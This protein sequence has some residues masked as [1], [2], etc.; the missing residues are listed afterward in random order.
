MKYPFLSDPIGI[1][2]RG[3]VRELQERLAE[4]REARCMPSLM[5]SSSSSLANVSAGVERF[6]GRA[7]EPFELLNAQN[8]VK[9]LSEFSKFLRKFQEILKSEEFLILSRKSCE[10]PR[11]FD[12]NR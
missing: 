7:I 9:F 5:P 3:E 4:E 10:I 6:D 12:Q 11:K 2:G 8:S 1:R